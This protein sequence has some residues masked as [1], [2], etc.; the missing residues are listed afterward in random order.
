MA[1]DTGARIVPIALISK[2]I[3]LFSNYR[4]RIGKPYTIEKDADIE[5][6]NKKLRSLIQDLI[7]GQ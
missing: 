6:E 3:P 5:E 4:I 1:R 2:G 7:D